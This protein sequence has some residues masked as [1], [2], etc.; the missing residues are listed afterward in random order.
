MLGKA[1]SASG[2]AGSEEPGF[3]ELV[4]YELHIEQ[5]PVLER[6]GVPSAPSDAGNSWQRSPSM[7]M[8]TM[9]HDA[10]RCAGICVRVVTFLRDQAR[11][12]NTHC[13]DRSLR[14]F[15]PNAIDV[16]PSRAERCTVDLR[17]PTKGASRRRKQTLATLKELA[18]ARG[19]DDD[20]AVERRAV[21]AGGFDRKIVELVE[22]AARKRGLASKLL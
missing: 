15:E 13:C 21:R 3:L 9:R 10:M 2:Y 12:W 20:V 8:P 17:D 22:D 7:A 19:G 18:V 14:E 6:E 1:W 5:G 11:S 4:L 16:I